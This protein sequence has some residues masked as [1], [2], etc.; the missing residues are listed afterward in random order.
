MQTW[1]LTRKQHRQLPA[2]DRA[3]YDQAEKYMKSAQMIAGG[4]KEAE[5]KAAKLFKSIGWEV[6]SVV[7]GSETFC[8][9]VKPATY[10]L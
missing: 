4:G 7:V 1:Q 8:R 9:I 2:D 5:L 10:N 3:I 6:E